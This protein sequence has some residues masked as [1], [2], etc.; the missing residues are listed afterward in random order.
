M[1]SSGWCSRVAAVVLAAALCGCVSTAP[2]FRVTIAQA[3]AAVFPS[4]VYV[5]VIY[6]DLESGIN[7]LKPSLNPGMLCLVKG[8]RSAKLERV[9]DFFNM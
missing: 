8:S 1:M 3:K 2:D 9:L 6:D 7:W 5:R 4:V